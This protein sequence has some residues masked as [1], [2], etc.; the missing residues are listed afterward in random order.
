MSWALGNNIVGTYSPILRAA[1][2]H[3]TD[4]GLLWTPPTW[5]HSV[6]LLTLVS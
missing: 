6:R 1:G 2:W 5:V 4:T 3:Q